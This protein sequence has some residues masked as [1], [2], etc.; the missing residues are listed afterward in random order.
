MIGIIVSIITLLYS[1]I[2]SVSNQVV[3]QKKIVFGIF[4]DIY[5]FNDRKTITGV[6]NEELKEVLS[7]FHYNRYGAI[8]TV[9]REN[10]NGVKYLNMGY[11]DG[12]AIELSCINMIDEIFLNM[13]MRL[14]CQRE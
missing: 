9:Y 6:T 12:T 13:I 14:L 7:G 2:D 10:L 1:S 11:L 8:Y 4:T 5:Y 3:E